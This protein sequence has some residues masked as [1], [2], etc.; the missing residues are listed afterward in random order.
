MI[1]TAG[2]AAILILV[3]VKTAVERVADAVPNNLAG[4]VLAW[5]G[6]MAFLAVMA[7]YAAV[8]LAYT[9][10]RS[11]AIPGTVAIGIAA[12]AAVGLMVY[13]LGPLGFPLRFTGWWPARLYD[14]AMA[15]GALLA[16]G[17]PVAAARV[18]TRRSSRSMPAGS[19]ARQGAMAGL[20]TGAAAALVVAAL[21]T[22][23][24][25]LL[26][27]DAGLRNW[28]AGHI[29]QWMPVVG[30]VAPVRSVQPRW[31]RGGEQRLRGRVPHR[32][33]A[34]PGGWCPGRVGRLGRAAAPILLARGGQDPARRTRQF[35][36]VVPVAGPGGG[37]SRGGRACTACTCGTASRC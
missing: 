30:Q 15:L 24:I 20:C 1:R 36:T 6:E 26:P 37:G 34:Q 27:Y 5:T 11:P 35:T 4:S 8:V 33:P 18:A 7:G 14:A 22:A 19:P 32:A 9:A 29:G 23:T 17:A 21:S 2:Y 25:A 28:A 10:R 16:L 12:G 31:L 13:V 3:L